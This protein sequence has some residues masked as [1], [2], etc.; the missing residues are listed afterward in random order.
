MTKAKQ[1]PYCNE[2]LRGFGDSMRKKELDFLNCSGPGQQPSQ[3]THFC[4][5][6]FYWWTEQT[7]AYYD[8]I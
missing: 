3:K 1:E 6:K 7:G 2:G 5:M 8:H 4:Y